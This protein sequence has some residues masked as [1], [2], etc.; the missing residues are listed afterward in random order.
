[1]PSGSHEG[2]VVRNYL[3]TCLELPWNQSSKATINLNKVEKV[4]NKEHYG[5]SRVKERILESLAVR[6]LNPHM[7]GQVICLV[8]P[9]GV[10]KS[11][12]QNLLPMQSVWNSNVFLWVVYVMNLRLW[13][14][15]KH[16]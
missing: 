15:V 4:L 5:L 16:M 10:G 12:I 11:S 9:P 8:G 7:N 2:S 6:K 1:M 3:E 13:G 14:T